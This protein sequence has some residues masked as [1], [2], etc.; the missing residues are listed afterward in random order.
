MADDCDLLPADAPAGHI[1]YK[2]VRRLPARNAFLTHPSLESRITVLG[3]RKQIRQASL[4]DASIG[5]A[6]SRSLSVDTWH[7]VI[8]FNCST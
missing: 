3:K 6:C 7:F 4:A 1:A 5:K 8:F 2:R